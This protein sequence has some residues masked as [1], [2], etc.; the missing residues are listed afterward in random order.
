MTDFWDAAKGVLGAVAPLLATAVGGPLAGTAVSAI[1]GALGLASTTAPEQVAAAVAGASPD[2]LIA[3]R[4]ADDD[5]KVQM[6]TLGVAAEQLVYADK[7][8]ARAREIAVRDHT[9]AVLAYALTLG[10]FGFLA[11]LLFHGSPPE[12][13]RALDMILG[14]LT[15]VW[16][17]AMAYY[18][19]NSHGSE[20]KDVLLANSTPGG[21]APRPLS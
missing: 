1:C 17:G 11:V 14:G 19:G 9:P 4:K 13:Q 2:Q 5:F 20:A 18:F 3:L 6:Q 10:Y 12:N 16:L 7:S 15:T 21:A 8:N